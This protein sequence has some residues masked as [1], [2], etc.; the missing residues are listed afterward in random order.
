MHPAVCSLVR[1]R[2]RAATVDAPRHVRRAGCIYTALVGTD[3]V[4]PL[5]ACDYA[6]VR[7]RRPCIRPTIRHVHASR[8]L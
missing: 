5:H 2:A 7:A 8:R 6:F 1:A 3:V 4:E